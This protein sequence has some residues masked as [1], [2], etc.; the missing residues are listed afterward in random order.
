M[1][2][3]IEGKTEVSEFPERFTDPSAVSREAEPDY[4]E[5]ARK[6]NHWI[7]LED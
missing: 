3:A 4:Q 2:P 5:V 6:E 1:E 7:Y